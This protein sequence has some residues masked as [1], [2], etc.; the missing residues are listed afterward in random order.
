[1]CLNLCRTHK[2]KT[3]VLEQCEIDWYARAHCEVR[4]WWLCCS[5]CDGMLVAWAFCEC[6][7][8]PPRCGFCRSLF[9]NHTV[10]RRWGLRGR[11]GSPDLN[12][13]VVKEEGG[14]ALYMVL[15]LHR[16]EAC[17]CYR[18]LQVLP[19][20]ISCGLAVQA[21]QHV[22]H[23][24]WSGFGYTG[25]ASGLSFVLLFPTLTRPR[26]CSSLC[27]SMC[28]APVFCLCFLFLFVLFRG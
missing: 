19:G 7:C 3:I 25:P 10:R 22:C 6:W 8:A 14:S 18:V 28:V 1:M 9:R 13:D 2:G 12:N 15:G 11:A 16:E 23:I 4:R 24:C 26:L 27:V 5:R 20:H 21:A 17:P